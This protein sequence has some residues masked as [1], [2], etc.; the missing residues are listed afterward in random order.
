MLAK[1]MRTAFGSAFIGIVSAVF[2]ISFAAILYNGDLSPYFDRGVG[3]TLMGGAVLG[4][5]GAFTLSYRGTVVQPQDVP[6][7]LLAGG[8]ATLIA[9]HQLSGDVLF[10]TV[11][12][13]TAVASLATGIVAVLVG[14]FKLAML[15]RYIPYPVLAG[16]LAA[17]GLLLLL[18]GLGVAVDLSPTLNHLP[19]FITA[20]ALIKWVPVCIAAGG[21]VLATRVFKS[22]LTLPL[23]LLATAIGFYVMIAFLGLSENE[24]RN[25]G[26]LL[27]PFNG[28]SFT[29]GL[30]PHLIWQAD[31]AAILTQAPVVVAIVAISMVGTTL[32]ASGLELELGRDLD[33]NREVSGVGIGN[34]L[35]AFVGGLP[36]YHLLGETILAGRL[37][38]SGPIAG[39]SSAIGC[40]TVLLFGGM[41]LSVMPVGL[42]ATVIAFLGLDLLYTWLWAERR[43]LKR[44]DYAIVVLIPVIAVTFSFLMAITTGLVV[45]FFFFVIA[46]AKLDLIR[47]QTTVDLRRSYVE[48]PDSELSVL[49][50]L[51]ARAQIVELS[52]YLF[53]AS[54]N[55]LRERIKS[56]L[57]SDTPNI[58]WLIIDFKYVTGIDI[59]T[60][61]MFQRLISDCEQLEVRVLVSGIGR[62]AQND[63]VSRQLTADH[64]DSLDQALEHV[65]D[66]IL[67]GHANECTTSAADILKAVFANAPKGAF[68]QYVKT[69]YVSSGDVVIECG[70]QSDEIYIL[71][72]GQLAVSV[73]Q[74][75]GETVIVAR[76]RPGSVVGEM[77]HYSGRERMANLVADGPVQLFSID[78]NRLKALESD[79]PSV[80]AGFH[81]FIAQH[82]ARRLHRTTMLLRDQ[83]F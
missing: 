6:A 29:T 48:R 61:H 72:S 57:G 14:R 38:L 43:H 39:I 62:I 46:Y 13:L 64:F 50:R 34:T 20:Q 76:I 27:G 28:G 75:N 24:A 10:A 52:G 7:I 25:A 3:L 66:A 53:F 31:W 78:M 55:V 2:A 42:F 71:Q 45:A 40:L 12:C 26:F 59:S 17:T 58:E 63:I 41:I 37:G 49:A 22:N 8:A 33:M 68:E 44:R 9:Q 15:V 70:S 4:I 80:V 19:E 16:F 74:R 56:A 23:A 54:A 18:G 1:L 79:H 32:N 35:A 82:M 83:G 73:P 69:V 11:A 77:A 67:A 51:G 21:I 60:L 30:G 5:A 65:E 81:R 47:S 36:G